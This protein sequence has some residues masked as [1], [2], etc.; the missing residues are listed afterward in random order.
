MFPEFGE[1][2]ARFRA[3]LDDAGLDATGAVADLMGSDGT[4]N[5]ACHFFLKRGNA[6]DLQLQRT[7][8]PPGEAAALRGLQRAVAKNLDRRSVTTSLRMQDRKL[9]RSMLGRKDATRLYFISA[10]DCLIDKRGHG[11]GDRA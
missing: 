3:G 6:F 10:V 4:K 11:A 8:Q 1:Q 5:I 7:A 2:V 9:D